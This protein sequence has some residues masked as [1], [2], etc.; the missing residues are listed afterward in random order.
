MV[1]YYNLM[2]EECERLEKE[3]SLLDKQIK[4]LPA[5][6]FCLAKNGKYYKWYE[7]KEGKPKLIK[8]KEREYAKKLAYRRILLEKQKLLKKE[9][10][11]IDLYLANSP[12]KTNIDEFFTEKGY[13]DLLENRFEQSTRAIEWAKEN[14]PRKMD[15]PETLNKKTS[16]GL[17][18]RSKSEAAIAEALYKHGIPFRYEWVQTLGGVEYGIDFTIMNPITGKIFYWEH[19]GMMDDGLYVSKSVPKIKA[20]A[21][22]GI[23][24]GVNLII[25]GETLQHPFLPD[26]AEKVLHLFFPEVVGL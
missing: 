23:Y 7:M 21:E 25:T 19:F 24:L 3:I 14:Y 16:F 10:I 1:I 2:K 13:D 9:K 8:K 26:D 22:N 12:R 18:V 5:K 15:H 4:K 11:A 17:A 6:D 20:Y